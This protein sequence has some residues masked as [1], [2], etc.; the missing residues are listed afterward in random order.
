MAVEGARYKLPSTMGN[1]NSSSASPVNQKEKEYQ[2]GQHAV[3]HGGHYQRAI[4]AHFA[5]GT[6]RH[7]AD[8]PDERKDAYFME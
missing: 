4:P 5:L 8:G 2:H 6:C 3:W 1:H 7:R